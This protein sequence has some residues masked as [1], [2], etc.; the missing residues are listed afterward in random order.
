M[1]HMKLCITWM[2]SMLCATEVGSI[3]LIFVKGFEAPQNLKYYASYDIY[4]LHD[5]IAYCVQ[6]L[7]EVGS[8][9]FIFVKGLEAPQNLMYYAS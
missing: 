7:T 4:V 6:R 3:F 9:F 5:C 2:Y 1:H 8:I